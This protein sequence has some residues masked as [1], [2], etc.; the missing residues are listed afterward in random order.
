MK[1]SQPKNFGVLG[2][3][4]FVV[5][6]AVTVVAYLE[7]IVPIVALGLGALLLGVMSLFLPESVSFRAG[8]LATLSS[9]PS[10][11]DLDALIRDLDIGPRGIY[12]PVQGFGAVPKVLLPLTDSPF[13][14]PPGLARTSRVFVILGKNP[15]DR[16]I[17]LTP[18][19]A[20]IVSALENCLQLD[21]ATIKL[22]ELETRLGFGLE[23]LGISKRA[24]TVQ[25]GERVVTVEVDSTS[26]VD[27]EERLRVMAPRLVTQIGSPLVSAIAAVVSKASG[28]Y[29]RIDNSTMDRSRLTVALG[30]FA[31]ESGWN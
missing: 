12:I 30:I 4:L 10:L 6:I 21:L 22:D 29:V 17:L 26:L 2:I 31:D 23:T 25:L 1:I 20:E 13:A 7:G 3:F 8:R 9:L 19:G 15:H 16:G 14:L 11:M 28:K 24:V 18:P 27:L 5:G